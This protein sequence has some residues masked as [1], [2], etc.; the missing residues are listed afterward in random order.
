MRKFCD[1]GEEREEDEKR[2]PD[3]IKRLR[4][5]ST[6]VYYSSA[7]HFNSKIL[8]QGR[9]KRELQHNLE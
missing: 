1:N 8:M 3:L 5:F 6:A 2:F 4:H 7:Q 9:L